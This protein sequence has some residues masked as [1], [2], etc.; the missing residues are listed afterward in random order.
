MYTI[1]QKF[2]SQNRPGTRLK[3]VG[4]VIHETA[5]PGAPALNHFTFYNNAYRGASAHAFIDW[6]PD[7]IQTIPWNEVAWHAGRTANL[8][9]IGI[10]LC[11][12][13]SEKDFKIVWDKAVW[14][15][16]Y[17]FKSILNITTITKNNLMSHYEVS[18][19]WKETTHVDPESYLKKYGK[20]VD[21]FRTAVQD[22]INNMLGEKGGLSLMSYDLQPI[23]KGMLKNTTTLECCSKPS[24]NART[25]TKLKKKI[26][27]PINIF[28]KCKNEGIEWYL[29]NKINEQWVAAHYV[30]ITEICN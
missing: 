2:I 16:A 22:Q 19:K 24:N 7:I 20:T 13:Q 26:H 11:H 4:I 5:N 6:L 28:A 17:L 30:E 1:V 23:A 10:E 18:M 27:E 8:N 3:P 29:V 25:G 15:F 21:G 12:A 9:Y 14:L